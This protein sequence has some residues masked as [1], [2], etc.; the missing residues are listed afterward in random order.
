MLIS[1]AEGGK[2]VATLAFRDQEV[3]ARL[4]DV[5]THSVN[6]YTVATAAEFRNQAQQAKLLQ[7]RLCVLFHIPPLNVRLERISPPC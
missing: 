2:V 3:E 7:A 6:F 4:T 5:V 1:W